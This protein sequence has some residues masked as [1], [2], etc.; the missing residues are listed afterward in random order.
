MTVFKNGIY[1]YNFYYRPKF[2]F[3]D[4]IGGVTVV[5]MVS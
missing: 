1:K 3:G 4:I 2:I 5:I